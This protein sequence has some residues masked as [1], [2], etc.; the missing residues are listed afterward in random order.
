MET[1]SADVKRVLVQSDFPLGPS[2]GWIKFFSNLIDSGQID[3]LDVNSTL[4]VHFSI[5]FNHK[6]SQLKRIQG[7]QIPVENRILV[8]LE[9]E[10]IL[11]KMHTDEIL[12]EYGT[13]FS[14]SPLWAADHR[15]QKFTY[16]VL[17]VK[18][19]AISLT[20]QKD[21]P[22]GIVQRNLYSCIKGEMYSFRRKVIFELKNNETHFELR[23][24]GWQ[25]NG[26]SN[27]IQHYRLL[28]FQIRN[29][30]YSNLVHK[31]KY[32]RKVQIKTALPV[33][34]KLDFLRR[35]KVAIIIE[36]SQDYVSEKIFDCFRAGVV[37]IYVGPD[38]S[39]FGIP[40]DTV[41]IAPAEIQKLMALVNN[42]DSFDLS[43]YRARA[44]DFMINHS[45]PWVEEVSLED[46]SYK[47]SKV[48]LDK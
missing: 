8:M 4:P 12:K 47:I 48:I 44:Q 39:L 32:F 33:T 17:P 2:R 31:P 43:E 9:C 19:N 14:P 38:L 18:Y 20:E 7:L 42:L 1:R 29:R 13:I 28:L 22:I 37:P 30:N 10:A 25:R 16:P 27:I 45:D 15:T 46:L 41:L 5:S 11:P 24:F 26:F 23:G 21:I 35:V 36:N 6:D 3:F 40:T 34:N